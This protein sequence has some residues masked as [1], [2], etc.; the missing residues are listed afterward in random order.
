MKWI[1][2][3]DRIRIPSRIHWTNF[4]SAICWCWIDA[5]IFVEPLKAFFMISSVVFVRNDGW[6]CC[7]F[8][9][10]TW[11]GDC[12]Y[13]LYA[14]WILL[15][16]LQIGFQC[17]ELHWYAISYTY[18]SLSLCGQTFIRTICQSTMVKMENKVGKY[19]LNRKLF[20]IWI[21]RENWLIAESWK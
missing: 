15:E 12:D 21:K 13:I 2:D 16:N 10:F 18:V 5:K 14:F 11:Y 3:T 4:D 20:P 6:Y 8:D 17:I 19:L 9:L 7:L 1:W